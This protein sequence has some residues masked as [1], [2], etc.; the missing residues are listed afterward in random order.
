MATTLHGP[1]IAHF[2]SVV[3]TWSPLLKVAMH[4]ARGR[5]GISANKATL[6]KEPRVQQQALGVAPPA[7]VTPGR[8]PG[9]R[10]RGPT[11]WPATPTVGVR[12]SDPS[13]AAKY[14]AEWLAP[15]GS[16]FRG[17][18]MGSGPGA[19]TRTACSQ[20][21]HVDDQIAKG[22][23]VAPCPG[24]LPCAV[25]PGLLASRRRHSSI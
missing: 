16:T 9:L 20:N 2:V 24:I 5:A 23:A 10:H 7:D 3:G 11:Q 21:S 25:F 8:G 4:E 6:S 1:Q 13:L 18:R 12:K 15:K 17:E 19:A 14:D 22:A